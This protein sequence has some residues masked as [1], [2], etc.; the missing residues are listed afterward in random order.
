MDTAY[1]KQYAVFSG[2][3]TLYTVQYTV[4]SGVDTLYTVQYAV[5]SG[6][7]YCLYKA[8]RSAFGG[9]EYDK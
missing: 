6:S 7:R 4:F 2:V 3:D 8:M 5:F 9:T 1:T